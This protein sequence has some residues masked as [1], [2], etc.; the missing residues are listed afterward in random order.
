MELVRKLLGANLVASEG[1]IEP[2]DVLLALLV[3]DRTVLTG[4]PVDSEVLWFAE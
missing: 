3:G 1:E 2:V 4:T